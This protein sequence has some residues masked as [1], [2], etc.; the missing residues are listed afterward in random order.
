MTEDPRSPLLLTS[1]G[2]TAEILLNRPT[3]HNCLSI[4]LSDRFVEAIQTIK[5]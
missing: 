4:E 5:N 1:D 3:V 2:D